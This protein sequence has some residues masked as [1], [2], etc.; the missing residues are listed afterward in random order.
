ANDSW[1]ML[2]RYET[3]LSN[4]LREEICRLSVIYEE[5]SMS[6]ECREWDLQEHGI[7][8]KEVSKDADEDY[9]RV[10]TLVIGAL[11][12]DYDRSNW[13]QL[14]LLDSIFAA[15]L[16]KQK[17]LRYEAA[18]RRIAEFSAEEYAR[19]SPEQIRDSARI[20]AAWPNDDV[21][22]RSVKV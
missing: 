1:R 19:K 21:L 20:A 22:E 8:W 13:A 5:G 3:A 14:I 9:R 11:Q 7:L 15:Y 10:C 18:H 16:R 4:R 6:T 12:R 2:A 17:A